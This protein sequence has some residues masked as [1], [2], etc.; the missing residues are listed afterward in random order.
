M[1]RGLL[2]YALMKSTIYRSG[3]LFASWVV[4]AGAAVTACGGSHEA[5]GENT[6]GSKQAISEVQSRCWSNTRAEYVG[7]G[8][9][10]TSSY[11]GND[12]TCRGGEWEDGCGG[13]GASECWSNSRQASVPSGACV[14]ATASDYKWY[15]C[16][17]GDWYLDSSCNKP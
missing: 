16:E 9:C 5:G 7:E 14:Q 6:E 11:D 10:V 3:P 4:V 1:A 8:T 15:R 12:Y 17:D 13:G 2:M